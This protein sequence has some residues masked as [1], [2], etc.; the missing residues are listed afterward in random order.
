[1][2]GPLLPTWAPSMRSTGA[3]R[4]LLCPDGMSLGGSA[5]H[6]KQQPWY[7]PGPPLLPRP[8]PASAPSRP[9]PATAAGARAAQHQRQQPHV[10]ARRVAAG[11]HQPRRELQPAAG[12]HP[13]HRPCPGGPCAAGEPAKRPPAALPAPRRRQQRRTAADERNTGRRRRRGS[14]GCGGGGAGAAPSRA[15]Q[16]CVGRSCRRWGERWLAILSS[17]CQ[18]T[19]GQGIRWCQP[20]LCMRQ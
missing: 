1:L 3:E 16:P 5:R 19:V 20:S 6:P 12:H 4:H 14:G 18:E 2:W 15:G 17:A 7:S 13:A 11:A 8:R 9:H 10:P